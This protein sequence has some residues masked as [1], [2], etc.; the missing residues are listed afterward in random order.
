[1][2]IDVKRIQNAVGVFLIEDDTL[3]RSGLFLELF[4]LIRASQDACSEADVDKLQRLRDA[5]RWTSYV[6]Q[7][8]SELET[9]FH[10]LEWQ[11]DSWAKGGS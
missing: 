9:V 2:A 11:R 1:M 7:D 6:S 4:P 3:C 8:L 5:I 10:R